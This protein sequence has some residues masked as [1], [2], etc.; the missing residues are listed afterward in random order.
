MQ[1]LELVS[2]DSHAV[3]VYIVVV[4]ELAEG[5]QTAAMAIRIAQE[6]RKAGMRTE[7]DLAGGK[8]GKQ[9]ERANKRGARLAVLIGEREYVTQELVLKDLR[10]GAQQTVAQA[11]LASVAGA[12][13]AV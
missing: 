10:D 5:S 3:Q 8:L 2:K 1:E 4:S 11:D 13:L 6:L 7:M 12:L 9:L